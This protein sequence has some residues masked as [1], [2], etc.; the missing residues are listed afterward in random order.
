MKN[1]RSFF[2][3]DFDVKGWLKTQLTLQAKGL[4]GHLDEIWPDIKESAWIGKE[5]EGWERLPYWLDGFIPLAYLLKDEAMIQKAQYYIQSI[6]QFQQGDGWICLVKK[7]NEK[8]MI[9]GL[10]F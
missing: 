5:K 6:I 8:N 10:F 4:S 7:N 1:L 3:L 2:V 9:Y